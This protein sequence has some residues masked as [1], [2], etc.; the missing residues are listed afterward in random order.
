MGTSIVAQ[1]SA[2]RA[3]R[4]E[5]RYDRTF[6]SIQRDIRRIDVVLQVKGTASASSIRAQGPGRRDDLV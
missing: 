5:I 4:A 1:F 6:F 3:A 2:D